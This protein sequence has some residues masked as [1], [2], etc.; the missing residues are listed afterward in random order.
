MAN[1][2]Q[3]L[4]DATVLVEKLLE[5]GGRSVNAKLR[6]KLGWGEARY[7]A[8]RNEARAAGLLGLARG[9]GGLVFLTDTAKAGLAEIVS[10]GEVAAATTEAEQAKEVEYYDKLF[11]TIQ[12]AWV[13]NEGFDDSVVEITAAKRVKGVGRWTVPDI[14]VIGKT[15]R[16]YVPGFEFAVQSIEIKRFESLDALAVFEAL[17]HRRAAHFSY[18]LVVNFPKKPNERD[19]EKIGQ[20]SQLCEE[21]DVGLVV[22]MKGDE[23]KYDNWEFQFFASRIEPDPDNLDG[24]IKQYMSAQ[25]KDAVSKMVR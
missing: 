22:V 18:L 11:P 16:Q 23:D 7:F 3:L 24:F 2:E 6:A 9:R 21:H 10:G 8:A 1:D 13:Q 25:S 15:V 5:L 12:E 14:V 4:D 19:N 20:V 17:N